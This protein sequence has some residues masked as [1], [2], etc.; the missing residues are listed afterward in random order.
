MV[1][2][3]KSK[4]L[5]KDVLAK[6]KGAKIGKASKTTKK[7]NAEKKVKKALVNMQEYA[8]VDGEFRVPL[9]PVAHKVVLRTAAPVVEKKKSKKI[10]K[11]IIEQPKPT[12]FATQQQTI[13]KEKYPPGLFFMSPCA[14]VDNNQMTDD[15]NQDKRYKLSA[16]KQKGWGDQWSQGLVQCRCVKCELKQV[17]PASKGCKLF[18]LLDLDNWGFAPL[19]KPMDASQAFL[20]K[21]AGSMYMW[22][23]Y[24]S[25]FRDY[26]EEHPRSIFDKITTQDEWL[27]VQNS[28]FGLMKKNSHIRLSPTG[29]HKQ[30]ADLS[31]L[32]MVKM[33][34]DRVH[35]V[36]ISHDKELLESARKVNDKV[37]IINPESE[38]PFTQ[39]QKLCT[40]LDL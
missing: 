4:T 7:T 12:F 30:S 18:V 33:L 40:E 6:E 26:L 21:A 24:G 20:K 9:I 37:R 23:F 1:Q 2:H 11:E 19:T 8:E 34:R 27:E 38:K 39:L 36:V 14:L 22:G 5:V 31:I 10:E 29:Y 15:A 3:K 32:N 28:A 16:L 17:V 13:N 35:M 25:G